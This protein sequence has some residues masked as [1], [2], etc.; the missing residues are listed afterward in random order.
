MD[1][2]QAIEGLKTC[3]NTISAELTRLTPLVSHLGH[4][5]VQDEIRQ[6][7]FQLTKDLEGVKKL[8]RKAEIAPS[9]Q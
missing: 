8:V 7:L 6:A 1:Q 5:N 2:A 3:C 4:K 9:E